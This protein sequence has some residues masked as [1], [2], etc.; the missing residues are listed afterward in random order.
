MHCYFAD[1]SIWYMCWCARWKFTNSCNNGHWELAKFL[2]RYYWMFWANLPKEAYCKRHSKAAS[3]WG[4]SWIAWCVGK[5]WLY[6][7][8]M[9]KLS[10]AMEG[11]YTCGVHGVPTVMLEVV[12][13]NDLWIWHAFLVWLDPTMISTCWT[14]H[15]C[16]QPNDKG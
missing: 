4:G 9:E 11:Q 5:Y 3:C 13:S 1:V 16:S 12:A 6:A 15:H 7:L 10:S 2:Q 8:G 14:N